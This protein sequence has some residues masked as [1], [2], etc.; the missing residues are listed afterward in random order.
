MIS[1]PTD[2]YN[3]VIL[4]TD[5]YD[6]VILV[7]DSYDAVI[8]VT[9]SYDAVILITDSYD[10]VIMVGAMGPKHVPLSAFTE[11]IRLV[12]PGNS[13]RDFENERRSLSF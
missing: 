7:T 4:V 2:S 12:K 13:F 10:A 3:A 5:S 6:A 9:E 11:M 8:V 1:I